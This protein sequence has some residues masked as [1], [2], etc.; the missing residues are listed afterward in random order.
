MSRSNSEPVKGERDA[1][2]LFG[3]AFCVALAFVAFLKFYPVTLGFNFDTAASF[4][5]AL[6]A[7]FHYHRKTPVYELQGFIAVALVLVPFFGGAAMAPLMVAVVVLASRAVDWLF[8]WVD[9]T[10]VPQAA[11]TVKKS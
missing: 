3:A 11:M 9:R 1:V 5:F 8:D 6:L 10:Y 4:V 7:G 2:R